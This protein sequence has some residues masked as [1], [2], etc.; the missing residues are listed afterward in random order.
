MRTKRDRAQEDFGG[1]MTRRLPAVLVVVMALVWANQL[2]AEVR[3]YSVLIGANQGA[4][5]E[6][7]L[8][9]AVRDARRMEAT[10]KA[11][12]G[13]NAEDVVVLDNPKGATVERVIAELSGRIAGARAVDGQHG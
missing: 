10:L 3:R 9:Y 1:P 5:D 4:P 11:I 7:D 2:C 13:F 6:R 8:L 12:G